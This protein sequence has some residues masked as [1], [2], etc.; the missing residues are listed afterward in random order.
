MSVS[1]FRQSF[2]TSFSAQVVA[3]LRA[4][5]WRI[6]LSDGRLYVRNQDTLI[7]YDIRVAR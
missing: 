4:S 3:A 1:R 6:A 7:V 5:S 2:F